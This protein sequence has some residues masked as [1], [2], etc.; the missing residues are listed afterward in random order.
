MRRGKN[1]PSLWS[2]EKYFGYKEANI[3]SAMVEGTAVEEAA[4]VIDAAE[5]LCKSLKPKTIKMRPGGR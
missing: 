3:S 2:T 5:T 1:S 4:G